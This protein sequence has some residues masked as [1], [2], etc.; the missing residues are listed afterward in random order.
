MRICVVGGGL[1]GTMLAWRLVRHSGVEVELVAGPA[2]GGDATRASGGIVRGFE[3]DPELSELAWRSLA[4]LRGSELLRSWS[5]YRE[6]GG[7]YVLG[8]PLPEERLAGLHRRMPGA[9][10]L[11]D[12]RTLARRFGLAGLPS[13]AVGILERGAGYLSPDQLRAGARADFTARGGALDEGVLRDLRP[14]EDGV[15]YATDRGRRCADAVVLA[16][17]A[18]TGRLLH[19]SGLPPVG[20]RTKVIQYALYDVRGVCPP[21]FVDVSSGLYGRPAGPGRMLF[22]LP[23]E[24]WDVHAGPQPFLDAEERAVRRAVALR[25]PGLQVDP[26]HR[27]VATAEAYVPQGRL[28]LRPVPS[29]P[30]GL[31]TFAGGSGAAAKT[32]LAAGALAADDLLARFGVRSGAVSAAAARPIPIPGGEPR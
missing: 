20:L 17:G 29:C 7:L 4:E 31:F 10:E 19:D 26:P 3:E 32:A 9:V 11:L 23:T 13:Q 8:E 25:L 6:T 27:S 28:A 5:G 14:G 15:G 18:W 24:R 2:G 12:R 1:A 30:A 16:A 22:G 21:P